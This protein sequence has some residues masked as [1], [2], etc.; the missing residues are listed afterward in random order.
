ME[1]GQIL[2]I[3]STGGI[4]R[5]AA[6]DG[7]DG[8]ININ[9]EKHDATYHG[10]KYYRYHDTIKYELTHIEELVRIGT[11][12]LMEDDK[13]SSENPNLLFKRG[14]KQTS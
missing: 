3:N 11:L 5:I 8:T 7:S 9:W 14:R 12:R 6:I 1:V 10:P 2:R 13:L 4:G